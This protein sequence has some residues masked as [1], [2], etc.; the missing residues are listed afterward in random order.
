MLYENKKEI[1]Y[2]I[3]VAVD[4][5]EARNGKGVSADV[6]TSLDELGELA[7]TAGQ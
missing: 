2:V 4:T 7:E 6:E 5:G 3:L 1:E